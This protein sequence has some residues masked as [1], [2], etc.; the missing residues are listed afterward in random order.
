MKARPPSRKRTESAGGARQQ[1]S[2][3]A[4]QT[5]LPPTGCV[6]CLGGEGGG[7]TGRG[8]RRGV[9]RRRTDGKLLPGRVH[10]DAKRHLEVVLLP[11]QPLPQASQDRHRGRRQAARPE[12]G[13]GAGA[14]T[15]EKK[16]GAARGAASTQSRRGA[17]L[18]FPRRRPVAPQ[19]RL[20][21]GLGPLARPCSVGRAGARSRRGFRRRPGRPRGERGGGVVSR[22]R[23]GW[24]GNG[25]FEMMTVGKTRGPRAG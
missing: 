22:R 23:I 11:I 7:G 25:G 15:A 19:R 14:S 24:P 1:P 20:A 4:W 16:R 5:P 13:G 3:S 9:E 8:E 17:A 10:V 18:F 12:R 6:P 21:G 2:S